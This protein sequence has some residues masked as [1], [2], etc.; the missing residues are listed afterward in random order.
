MT[1]RRLAERLL[2]LTRQRH[3]D[4]ELED[5]IRAHLEL[6]ERDAMANGQF[7]HGIVSRAVARAPFDAASAL[8]CVPR[9]TS[10]NTCSSVSRL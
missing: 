3:L 2:A 1:I 8:A 10:R 4:R 5:E 7:A 9:A 6:A